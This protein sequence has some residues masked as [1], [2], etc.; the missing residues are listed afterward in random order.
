[1]FYLWSPAWTAFLVK[2]SKVGAFKTLDSYAMRPP[3]LSRK[4][5]EV[6]NVRSASD[7]IGRCS[8]ASN[9]SASLKRKPS[10]RA[11]QPFT[12]NPAMQLH[13]SNLSSKPSISQ[14]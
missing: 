9:D 4:K 12:R 14:R 8:I 2:L 7:H 6:E 5:H 1:M 10:R 13:A 11:R 3:C